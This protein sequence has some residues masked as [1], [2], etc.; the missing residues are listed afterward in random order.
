MSSRRTW[1]RARW[2]HPLIRSLYVS[3]YVAAS[4]L[5][6][7][8]LIDMPD[9]VHHTIGYPLTVAM[10]LVLLV[11]IT[12]AWAAWRGCWRVERG[13]IWSVLAGIMLYLATLI[14]GYPR[15]DLGER[16]MRIM[17]GILPSLLLIARMASIWKYDEDPKN[18]HVEK[19]Q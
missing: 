10:G 16:A 4:L 18:W 3:A 19:D 2:R 15:I 17:W 5:G 6:L 11:S 7:G 1:D 9:Q 8:V 13:A 14:T 12:G